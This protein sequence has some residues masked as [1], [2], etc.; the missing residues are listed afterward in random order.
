MTPATIEILNAIER[1]PN[2]EQHQLIVTL[3]RRMPAIEID[4][5]RDEELVACAE[6]IFLELDQEEARSTKLE[7]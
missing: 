6:A 3:L 4:E 1:L 5:L 2:L 7:G